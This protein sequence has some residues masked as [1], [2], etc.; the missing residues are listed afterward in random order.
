MK[1]RPYGPFEYS[2]IIKRPRIAWP[3]DCRVALWVSP[4]VEFFALDDAV[5]VA[6]GGS[7]GKVPDVPVWAQRDY[8]NRVGVFRLMEALDRYSIRATV[9]LNSEV[10][11]HHPIIIEEGNKR[12]WEWMGHN[13][14]NT[15]RLNAVAPEEEPKVIK[16]TLDTIAGAAGTR[17]I[18]WLGAGLQETW[19]TLEYL[20]A[21][22]CEYVC[23][24]TNDD[25]P[26]LM[27]LENGRRLVSIPYSQEINDKVAFER[28]NRT[29]SEFEQMMRRQFDVLYR[30]GA[31]SARVMAICLHPYL[32]G[33]PHRIDALNSA[34]SYI[35]EHKDVWL[36]TGSEIARH[37]LAGT[38]L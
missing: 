2:P 38:G 11:R 7:G 27:N 6:A 15:K 9:A 14:T 30:E 31:E 16:R 17:P 34:L 1:P 37:Y 22:G 32:I 29:A 28:F 5:P 13:E 25:Q 10:C 4:N 26:Y 8:G 24:W 36:T 21:E 3:D 35:C 23:D 20:A 19:D 33:Q 18:G 12:R